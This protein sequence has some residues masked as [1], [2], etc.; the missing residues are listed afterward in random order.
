ML[1]I[2]LVRPP[3]VKT[4]CFHGARRPPVLHA[5]RSAGRGCAE[6]HTPLGARVNKPKQQEQRKPASKSGASYVQA[7]QYL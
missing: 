2:S 4:P 7:A 1:T 5:G 6:V 3:P